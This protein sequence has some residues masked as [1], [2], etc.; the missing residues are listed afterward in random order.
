MKK[1]FALILLVIVQIIV[2]PV[3]AVEIKQ[4]GVFTIRGGAQFGMSIEEIDA[5]EA[6][7]GTTRRNIKSEYNTLSLK[8]EYIAGVSIGRCAETQDNVTYYFDENNRFIELYY[9]FGYYDSSSQ[10][11]S[12]FNDIVSA[13]TNKYQQP[14]HFNDG[15]I[16]SIEGRAWDYFPSVFTL[17]DYAQWLLQ[18]ESGYV[19]CDV[20]GSY[21]KNSHQISMNY[22]YLTEKEMN[23]IL[24]SFADEDAQRKNSIDKDI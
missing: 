9:W 2:I 5:I 19:L 10:Y 17:S 23:T 22:K 12:A 1:T 7:N 18:F 8:E 20:V 15:D 13:L 11:K 6:A 21:S 16:F 3:K 14:I 24:Q 4:K